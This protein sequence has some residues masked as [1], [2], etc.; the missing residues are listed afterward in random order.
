MVREPLSSQA[1]TQYRAVHLIVY[2]MVQGVGFR[3]FTRTQ[4]VRLG[5]AGWVRNRPD[6]TVEIWAEGPPDRLETLI[7]AV[8][9]GPSYSRVDR[10]E[11]TWSSPKG[12]RG[13]YIRS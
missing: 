6:G 8:R 7:K 13:F 9:R 10:V 11:A 3:Y 4:A 5:I 1:P 12:H 2:G